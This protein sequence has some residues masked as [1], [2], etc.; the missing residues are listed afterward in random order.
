MKAYTQKILRS[1]TAFILLLP[2]PELPVFA[3]ATRDTFQFH[4]TKAIASFSDGR[5]AEAVEA[6]DTLEE[7]YR[8]E[9]GY[10]LPAYRKLLLP[11]RG[12]A[13]LRQGLPSRAV[14][15]L[16][17]YVEEFPLERKRRPF[18]LFS[19]A[20]A[21]RESGDTRGAIRTYEKLEHEFPD[22]S[23]SAISILRRA[24]LLFQEGK[25]ETSLLSLNELYASSAAETLRFRA[26]LR[27]LQISIESGDERGAVE[28]L[29]ETPWKITTMPELALLA[30]SALRIGDKLLERERFPDAIRCFRMVP[31]RGQLLAL[32]QG[33]LKNI[34]AILRKRG[35]SAALTENALWHD[36]Y[37]GLIQRIRKQ[38]KGLQA[39]EDYTPRFRLR[40]GQAMLLA[41]R[42]E[43]AVILFRYLSGDKNLDQEIR[44][45][46]HYRW[47]LAVQA[48]DKWDDAIVIAQDF[49]DRYPNS[50]IA[51]QAVFL[52]ALAYQEQR[53]YESA[54]EVLNDLIARNLSHNAAQRWKFALGFCLLL[55]QRNAEARGVFEQVVE[56]WPKGR[57][58]LNSRY[59]HAL[60]WFFEKEYE[61]ALEELEQL[62][63]DSSG[64]PMNSEIRYRL[65][66]VLYGMRRYQ[67]ALDAIDSFLADFPGHTRFA[68]SQVL[69]GDILMGRGELLGAAVAF[70]KVTPEAAGLFPYAIFQSGKIYKAMEE[71]DR[72][73]AHFSE[74]LERS[75]LE[76]KPRMSEALYWI[77]WAHGRQGRVEEAFPIFTA[78]LEKF[79]NDLESRE[80]PLI[81]TALRKQYAKLQKNTVRNGVTEHPLLTTP[82]FESWVERERQ[83]ALVEGQLTYFSRLGL[84]Q[85]K[86]LEEGGDSTAA[87]TIL[88]QIAEKVPIERL[89]AEALGRIGLALEQ[90]DFPSATEYLEAL[91]LRYPDFGERAMAYYGLAQAH[92]KAS[93]WEEASDLLEKLAGEIP[94]HPLAAE[95]TLLL[96]Q[97]HL[98][99]GKPH[100]A[101]AL[102]EGLLRL[103]SARGRP[104]AEAL[105][106]LAEAH[107]M[108]GEEKK[109]IAYLQRIYTLYRAYSDL[110]ADAYF[111]SAQLFE[112]I[113]DITAAYNTLVELTDSSDL[114]AHQAYAKGVVE[115]NRLR[116]GLNTTL[117]SPLNQTP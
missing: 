50:E 80:I 63:P 21:Y 67:Q 69:R 110:V 22:T 25:T 47:I 113:G 59:W 58:V 31:P 2:F 37:R 11:A 6:F 38:L 71:Y 115:K 39:G 26:R 78:A 81:L 85:S 34:E 74:Y 16:G 65:A 90:L 17:R 79:G 102:H 100:K 7:L 114:S 5:Y 70:S 105:L 12:Y 82:S 9:P 62:L 27:A 77:G 13:Q 40:F 33:R 36:Y 60:T 94:V 73:I 103:K 112:V 99:G 8:N 84:Y 55:D 68:E 52:I 15:S 76:V 104:H 32:Q 57:L 53:N 108:L 83:R 51:P 98:K 4:M 89:D 109:A 87:Q 97:V 28:T 72:M 35:A 45:E 92:F 64:H 54:I 101:I 86:A 10:S 1:T 18:V 48:L 95:S 19:L 111:K 24:E 107:Q 91:L 3:Q 14:E 46:A 96:A 20:R 56:S 106:G 49:M 93:Q 61:N 29:L 41:G 43:E 117:G 42:H 66:A 23:E 88:L 44:S 116:A 75:D 30:F